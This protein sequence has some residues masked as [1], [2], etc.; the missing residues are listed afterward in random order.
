MIWWKVILLSL[1]QVCS[2]STHQTL[3]CLRKKAEKGGYGIYLIREFLKNEIEK[4]WR[5]K[6]KFVVDSKKREKRKNKEFF[7]F[8]SS[9][10]AALAREDSY[11]YFFI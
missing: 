4:W 6:L 2:L 1:T 10:W 3:G 11:V 8:F 7:L 9:M 5:R